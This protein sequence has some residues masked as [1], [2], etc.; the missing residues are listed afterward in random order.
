M[1]LKRIETVGFKSFARK[2]IVEFEE[3]INCIVGPNGSG[4]SNI[5]DAIKWV[6]GAQSPKSLRTANMSEVIFAGSSNHAPLNL[7]EVHLIFNNEDRTLNMDFDEVSIGRRV[8]RNGRSEYLINKQVVRLKDVK[9]L[10]LDTGMSSDSLMHISQDKVKFVV[11][12]KAVERRTIIE[13]AAGVLK[14]KMKKH[15]TELKLNQ[16]TTNLERLEDIMHELKKQMRTLERQA[17]KAKASLEKQEQLKN[18]EIALLVSEMTKFNELNQEYQKTLDEYAVTIVE[19][20]N[21]QNRNEAKINQLHQDFMIREEEIES[22]GD[23]H[24]VVIQKLSGFK[25]QKEVLTKRFS[26]FDEEVNTEK[27]TEFVDGLAKQLAKKKSELEK[28]QNKIFEIERKVKENQVTLSNLQHNKN[29]CQSNI[30]ITKNMSENLFKGVQA[31]VNGSKKGQLTG[32]EGM[33]ADLIELNPKYVT[34]IETALQTALQHVVCKTDE[35]AKKAIGYLKRERLGRATFLPM[36]VMKSRA[37]D[38]NKLTSIKQKFSD[39]LLGSEVVKFS[40]EYRSVVENLLGNILICKDI[41]VATKLARFVEYRFRIVTLDGD[42]VNAGGSMS[43][44]GTP[45]KRKSL[46]Q[47]KSELASGE[48]E[49]A[50][51]ENEIGQLELD[52]NK[53]RISINK[54]NELYREQYMDYMREESNYQNYRQDLDTLSQ[55]LNEEVFAQLKEE[56]NS[57]LNSIKQ[58]RKQNLDVKEQREHL[59]R[60]NRE[61]GKFLN[62]NTNKIKDVEVAKN[63]VELEIQNAMERLG[64][65]ET[66]FEA[67]KDKHVLTID[68]EV[69]KVQVRKLKHQIQT[70]GPVNTLAI[71]DFEKVKE[72]YDHLSEEQADLIE[73]R[74]TLLGTIGELDQVMVERFEATFNQVNLRFGEVFRK[75]FGGGNAELRLTDKSNMLETGVDIY[76]QPPGTKITNHKLLSGGQK[77]MTSLALLFTILK[78]RT[79]PY[80]ILDEVEAALDEANVARF[81]NLMRDFK[82]VTQFIVITHRKGT[83]EK[84]DILY[85]VTMNEAGITKLV[86]VRLEDTI[87]FLDS[88][89]K[90]EYEA[91]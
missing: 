83:M 60:E 55:S 79:I 5:S 31:V 87:D 16:T 7:A 33:V 37:I 47:I 27:L 73:G 91:K 9:E 88:D 1:F 62:Q 80:C 50:K 18:V 44:G 76:V 6:L 21:Q 30:H 68:V 17:E 84:A 11:D 8:F 29:K 72:R 75:L 43:G 56:E 25:G 23:D 90:K 32:I 13:E 64:E 20:S 86:S 63:R 54:N 41:D 15:E 66:T 46:L 53:L 10:I 35:D 61:I 71:E 38:K 82:G 4:K 59:E 69:A 45:N 70:I 24:R 89:Q 40:N 52:T 78:V 48:K 85:G 49:L 51:I 39:V 22:L 2:T 14:Y 57:L 65:Y 58:L 28:S 81:G 19:M 3:G 36:N 74:D 34:A 67:S 42:I 77:T 12:C 26:Q